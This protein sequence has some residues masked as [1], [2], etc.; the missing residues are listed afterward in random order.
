MEHDAAAPVV[1]G[2]VVL[3]EE[4][5]T[6]LRRDDT[7]VALKLILQEADGQTSKS[8]DGKKIFALIYFTTNQ[9]YG[10]ES[11]RMDK[12]SIFDECQ[13]N[14]KHLKKKKNYR[15]RSEAYCV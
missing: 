1:G 12:T 6:A 14:K 8:K 2:V 4:V 15:N 9:R 3:H 7:V 5:V 11:T 13:E 10:K